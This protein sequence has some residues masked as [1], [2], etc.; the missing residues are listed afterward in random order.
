MGEGEEELFFLLWWRR[1]IK[2]VWERA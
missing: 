2:Y 1:S